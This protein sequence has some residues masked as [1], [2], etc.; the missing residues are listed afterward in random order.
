VPEIR[1][2][3]NPE[4]R[5]SATDLTAAFSV[6]NGVKQGGILS[7]VLF[8]IYAD[9]LLTTIAKS[10]Q[11][12]HIERRFVGALGYADDVAL[13][14]PTRSA[15]SKMLL[16]AQE[17][18]RKLHIRFNV[19][20]SQFLVFHPNPDAAI[21]PPIVFD[22]SPIHPVQEAVHLGHILTH[23]KDYRKRVVEKGVADI[24]VRSNILLSRF[25]HCTYTVLYKLF[26]SFCMVAYGSC[27]WDVSEIEPFCCAWRKVI[28]R[29][30]RLPNTA[31]SHLLPDLVMDQPPDVQLKRRFTKFMHSCST[32]SNACLRTCAKLA[33]QGSRSPVGRSVTVMIEQH[34]LRRTKWPSCLKES[35]RAPFPEATLLRDFLQWNENEKDDGLNFIINVLATE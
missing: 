33:L 10:G 21:E 11:G 22:G 28:R 17:A 1:N 6:R 30:L 24:T 34:G 9:Y 25:G 19:G 26:K 23:P 27:L 13:M 29:I 16:A 32:S 35:K 15:M 3:R 31:H 20:K 4:F 2:A 8:A 7:P 14:A 12:C 18:G 5:K